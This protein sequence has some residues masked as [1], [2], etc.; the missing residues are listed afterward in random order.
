MRLVVLLAVSA[1]FA[2]FLAWA[3]SPLWSTIPT[4]VFSV[5]GGL[6]CV[7]IGRTG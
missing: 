7:L 1:L 6:V 5:L 2:A 4:I 3:V